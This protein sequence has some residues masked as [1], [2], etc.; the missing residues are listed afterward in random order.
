MDETG[1]KEETRH[2]ER[3]TWNLWESDEQEFN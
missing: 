2:R 1:A 3:M